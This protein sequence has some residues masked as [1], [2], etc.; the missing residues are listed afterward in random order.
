MLRYPLLQKLADYGATV[1]AL[2]LT[3]GLK[4]VFEV[5]GQTLGG[6]MRQ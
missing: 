2:L 3:D 1:E 4:L 5:V 6:N